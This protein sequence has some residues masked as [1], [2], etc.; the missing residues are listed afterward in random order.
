M[1]R[2]R[3]R[4]VLVSKAT[5]ADRQFKELVQ[6]CVKTLR[7]NKDQK[8][9]MIKLLNEDFKKQ[10]TQRTSSPDTLRKEMTQEHNR[11]LK[12]LEGSKLDS[13]FAKSIT[14]Q[15]RALKLTETRNTFAKER[16]SLPTKLTS[17]KPLLMQ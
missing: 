15:N 13:D 3:V 9:T 12:L 4:P 5:G 2:Q 10:F 14:D 7:V 16:K 11:P 17:P 6:D 1:K 8:H